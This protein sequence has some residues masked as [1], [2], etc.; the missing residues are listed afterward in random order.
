MSV[1]TYRVFQFR[2]VQPAVSQNQPKLPQQTQKPAA[3]PARTSA[4]PAR[5]SQL[6][7][8]TL[9]AYFASNLRGENINTRFE[10]GMKE[11]V[12]G[13]CRDAITALAQVSAEST[14]ARAA[15]F[16]SGA[17]Q[18]RLGNYASASEILRKVADAG[19]S[20]QQEAAF[21][22]LA[23]IALTDNDPATARAYLSR[24]I[25]LR[26]DLEERARAQDRQIAE[27]ISQNQ[28]ASM[29]NPETN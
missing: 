27:L 24:T 26:G 15:E 12:S 3:Q 17:C 6:A 28:P 29:K 10:A 11:Y 19:N 22:S 14:Q 9:P 18:I 21:Y 1:F 16:Y 25:S 4:V 2:P 20:P 8:L 5:F 23:Q 7:D 13:N